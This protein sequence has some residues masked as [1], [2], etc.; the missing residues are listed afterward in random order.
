MTVLNRDDILTVK[1]ISIEEIDVPEWGGSVYV[2]GMNGTERDTFEASIVQQRGKNASVNMAN[3]RAKLAAQTICNENGERLFTD[4]DIKALGKKSAAAL[5]RVF[6][7]AQKLSGIS[8]DDVD[9]LAQEME[10]NPFGG[11][12]SD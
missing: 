11:S 10:E 2:K 1:D 8:G 5:Q 9:E 7:I 4:A 6:D 12:P 3:I